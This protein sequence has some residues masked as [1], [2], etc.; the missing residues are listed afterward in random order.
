[1]RGQLSRRRSLARVVGVGSGEGI[2]GLQGMGLDVEVA[3]AGPVRQGE[4]QRRWLAAAPP[5]RF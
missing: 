4:W 2:I 1:M 3:D 5:A